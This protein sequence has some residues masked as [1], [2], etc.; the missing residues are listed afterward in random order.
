[1]TPLIHKF[2]V[3]LTGISLNNRVKSELHDMG[4]IYDLDYRCVVLDHGYFYADSL[5]IMDELGKELKEDRDYQV[6]GFNEDL[7]ALTGK[8]ACAVIVIMNRKVASRIYVDAQM[9]G[10]QYE[11]VAPAIDRTVMGLLNNTRPTHWKNIEGKPDSYRP[12]GHMHPLWELYGFTPCVALFNRMA[13][14]LGKKADKILDS[15]Y[16]TFDASMKQIEI[17]QNSVE[18][19]LIAHMQDYDNPHDDT[20]AKIQMGNVTNSSTA[21]ETQARQTNGSLMDVYATPWSIAQS[22]DA[23][24]TPVLR[25][26][27][28]N[29]NNPH[30][31]SAALLNAYT[32]TEFNNKARLYTDQGAPMDR[33]TLVFGLTPEQLRAH[34]QD[35]NIIYNLTT[36][37]Y[38]MSTF[39][40]PLL[41]IAPTNQVYTGDRG[42]QNLDEVIARE[43]KRSTQVY[44]ITS[45]TGRGGAV[46]AANTSFPNAPVGSILFYHYARQ[47]FSYNGNGATVY[48]DTRS[49]MLLAK[50]T[51]GWQVSA[52]EV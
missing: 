48:N 26:H 31:L 23:N 18:S 28:D 15:I 19:L 36:G 3:D 24:F 30:G 46:P 4:R 52:G 39:A 32:V 21:T 12:G 17:E 1:M 44:Y 13:V 35:N 43:V 5:H 45:D 42:W 8:S 27:V 37:Q 33:S 9:A 25:D 38:P 50:N 10:G 7:T 2:P 51:S 34:A 49:T 47:G 41:G 22:L 29:K 14:G 20:A 16:Q 40:N 11:K 6:I